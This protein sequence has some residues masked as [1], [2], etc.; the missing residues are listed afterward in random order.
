MRLTIALVGAH[1]AGKSTLG[2]ALA[3][4]LGVPFHDEIGRRLLATRV[5]GRR[6][7]DAQESFDAEVFEAELARDADFT[8][9]LRVVET[10]HP[11]NLAYAARRSPRV[12]ARYYGLAFHDALILPVHASV[13]TRRARQN[14]P[15]DPHFFEAVGRD[16]ETQA[17]ALGLRVLAPVLND[18]ALA[19]SVATALARVRRAVAAGRGFWASHI[20]DP[21]KTCINSLEQQ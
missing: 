19:P 20:D 11:G 10:W 16:A 14:E 1:A 15:G 2:S 7:A 17:L 9:P 5:P 4:G 13:A 18:G 21:L 12:A 3:A 8:G 6:A